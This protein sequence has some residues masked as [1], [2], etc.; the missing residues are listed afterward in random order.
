MAPFSLSKL[1][2][3]FSRQNRPNVLHFSSFSIH[4]QKR[5]LRAQKKK[6]SPVVSQFHHG[7]E[8]C[9]S[10]IHGVQ[11][12]RQ[13]MGVPKVRCIIP[14]TTTQGPNRSY[15]MI[16]PIKI[17]SLYTI[18]NYLNPLL[19]QSRRE[20]KMMGSSL[21]S[22]HRDHNPHI[23]SFTSIMVRDKKHAH[24]QRQYGYLRNLLATTLPKLNSIS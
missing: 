3:Q 14:F 19:I 24:E 7:F 10:N 1:G 2:A 12:K 5:R 17:I 21:P 11:L 23:I 20:E 13:P 15:E 9:N 4:I 6:T 22:Y 18:E 8:G 16:K